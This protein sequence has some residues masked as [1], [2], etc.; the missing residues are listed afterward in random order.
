[1]RFDSLAFLAFLP[2]TVGLCR[3]F[4]HKLRKFLLLAASY[5]FFAFYSPS[6]VFLLI[7]ITLV[8]YVCARKAVTAYESSTKKLL[9]AL[10]I[11]VA[12]V[13]LFIYKYFDAAYS[14]FRSVFS[15][16]GL[17]HYELDLA[18][19]LG[20][21]FFTLRAVMYAVDVYKG[22]IEPEKDVA[23]FALYMAFFPTLIAGPLEKP[24]ELIEQ[25]K[26]KKP[27]AP[28][29]TAYGLKMLAIGFFKVL[30]VSRQI[31]P[32]VDTVFASSGS[33]DFAVN[34]GFTVLLAAIMFFFQ[35]YCEF[36]GYCDIAVG[37]AALIGIKLTANYNAPYLACGIHNLHSRFNIT[38]GTFFKDYVYAPMGGYD[39]K[40]TGAYIKLAVVFALVGLWYGAG[41]N[42][43]LFG[44]IHYA[45]RVLC[46]L[47]NKKDGYKSKQTKLKMAV[48]RTV[49]F[50][51]ACFSLTVLRAQSL[52][53]LGNM[54]KTLFLGWGG[55]DIYAS[56]AAIGFS[57]ITFITALASILTAIMLD[58]Y[59]DA[60]NKLSIDK[61]LKIER[62]QT[63]IVLC[64]AI[65]MAWLSLIVFAG[66]GTFEYFIF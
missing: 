14:G 9:T 22:N 53:S 56:I 48:K 17:A 43:L 23:Y 57:P 41:L 36:S 58:R 38:L 52:K 28:F 44:L 29:D 6:L 7:G 18:V 34:N 30:A 61:E 62:A 2:I 25:F 24:S 16:F 40:K 39:G 45:A 49:T 51:F 12:L 10:P 59:T 19:P 15:F 26:T 32:V 50:T 11:A 66:T 47:V 31:A 46:E 5:V 13:A 21:S 8:S 4:P 27:Y 20:I 55:V 33:V 1:M 60:P 54:L 37:C 64:W 42:F 3:I 35:I 63:Y 65:A